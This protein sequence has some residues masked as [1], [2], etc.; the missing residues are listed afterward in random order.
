VGRVL[1]ATFFLVFAY[2]T[3]ANLSL[4]PTAIGQTPKEVAQLKVGGAVATPLTLTIA[5]LK[6]MPRTTLH[7]ETPMTISPRY[8]KAFC[9]RSCSTG[10][11]R[12]PEDRF[13]GRS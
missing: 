5:D 11:A 6:K 7:V 4:I 2:A 3:S 10:L 9:S 13:G 12:L 1:R 8:T